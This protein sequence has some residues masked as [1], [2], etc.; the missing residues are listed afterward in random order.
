[1]PKSSE[2]LWKFWEELGNLRKFP[3]TSE[4]LQT[5]FWG[6][7]TIYETFGKLRKQFKSVFQI[8]LWFSKIFGNLQKFSE[9]F[10]NG[11]EVIFRCFYD[12]LKF[13]ENLRKSSEVFGNLWKRFPDMI[14]IVRNGSQ[15]LKGFG[16]RFWEVLKWTPVNC[17]AQGMTGK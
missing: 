2:N 11:S 15:E 8:F 3:K 13:S 14:G 4:T 10:G 12:F 16:A 6:A 1:M 17:Y 7:Y 5:R 9:N